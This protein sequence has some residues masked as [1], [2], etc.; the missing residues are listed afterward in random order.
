MEFGPPDA[1]ITLSTYKDGVLSRVAHDLDLR[2]A[3][4]RVVLLADRAELR[5]EPDSLEVIGARE[6][7][8]V[9]PPSERD[10]RQIE[11]TIREEVLEVGRYPELSGEGTVRVDADRVEVDGSLTLHGRTRPCGFT[12]RRGG[13]RLKG[14]VELSPSAYGIRPYQA[15]LGAIRLQDRVTVHL[16]LPDGLPME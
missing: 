2:V 15:L 11:R 5:V 3:R 4:F 7:G 9:T 8:L 13:G 6:H 10:R 14:E 12:L 1:R 16:D